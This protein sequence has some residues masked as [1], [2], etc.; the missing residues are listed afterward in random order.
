[1]AIIAPP[2]PGHLNPL[3]VL[4]AR[5]IALGHRVTIVHT[6][7]VARYVNT[8]E[9]GFA[10]LADGASDGLLD[11][12]LSQLA[13]ATGLLGITRMIAATARMTARLLDEAPAV[14]E[15]I[16]AEAVI[17]DAAEPAGGLIARRLGLPHVVSITGL[18]LMREEN[19][20][21]P[22]LRWPYRPD[23]SGRA[24]NRGGYRVSDLLMRPI[25]GVL[26]QRR[27]AWRIDEEE[28][29]G[30]LVH[31][32]QCPR[33]LDFPRDELPPRFHYGGPWR[34]PVE[35]WVDRPDDP[36]P[37]IF[38]SLGSLQGSRKA[39]FATMAA[40]CAAVG[41]R[42]VIGHGGGLTADEEAALPGDPLVRDYWPQEA[43][44]RCCSAAMLHGGFNT[45]L[46]AVAA[47]VPIVAVPIAF[48]QPGTAARLARIG[49]AKV[50]RWRGLTVRRLARA[51]EEVLAERRYKEAAGKLADE[52]AN[53]GGAKTAAA[54]VSAALVDR[55]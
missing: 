47:R 27:R 1:M 38:C 46:D 21:P 16:G 30:P 31:V 37:L 53:A 55:P 39:L 18:P 35:P 2:T 8:P 54:I 29:D 40:A 20:P 45:V 5:L 11:T 19:V 26:E 49:A 14:L 44:L 22:F 24:R 7:G 28:E 50:V 48:E 13:A 52:M 32:A 34:N 36:L 23:G 42:A 51:L 25:S 33:G 3:Q 12:Y 15:R 9:V 41:A 17:A 43:V 6:G 10:P 4:G